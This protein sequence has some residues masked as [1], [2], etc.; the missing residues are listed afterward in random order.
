ME[1]VETLERRLDKL[2]NV[3]DYI[4]K[5]LTTENPKLRYLVR[6]KTLSGR[7]EWIEEIV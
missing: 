5:S 3:F 1:K 2:L 4:R 7:P 6:T